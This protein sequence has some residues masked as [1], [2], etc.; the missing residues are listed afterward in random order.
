MNILFVTSEAYPLIKTGGLA[1]VSSGL[2]A[3]LAALGCDVRV[4]LPAYPEALDMVEAKGK[5]LALGDLLETGESR[6]LSSRMPDSGV[7][8]LLVDCPALFDRPGGPYVDAK[9]HIWPDNHLRFAMLSMAAA[10]VCKNGAD[11][12]RPDV[13]H[14]NDWHTGLVPAYLKRMEGP[15]IP[16][17]FTI[18]NLHYQ[19]LFERKVLEGIGLTQEDFTIDGVEYFGKVSFMKAGIQFSERITTVSPTYAREIQDEKMGEGL[20]GLLSAKASVLSGILNGVDY[21]LWNPDTDKAISTNYSASN[22]DR[23]VE[24]KRDLQRDTGLGELDEAPLLGMVCRFTHQKGIDLLLNALA[25][26]FDL[27]CQLV[28]LGEGEAKFERALRAA[29][30][31]SPKRMAVTIGYDEALA[32][33][34]QAGVDMVLV[35]SR[36][37]P[38]G[39]TQLYALKYGTLPVARRTGGLADSVLDVSESKAGTGFVFGDPT[40]GE[41]LR[42]VRRGVTLYGRPKEWRKVQKTAMKQDFSWRKAADEY[43]SLYKELI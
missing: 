4:I 1:D 41:L 8:V 19:G 42:A 31:A 6:L 37:E 40:P 29:A 5:S 15:K 39:L 17:V 28:V 9:G 10:R 35:P 16:S 30:A 34:I 33:R 24:N 21:A 12:W 14:A 3:A 23:K 25:G 36:Y 32:H 38:C 22:L 27:G 26:I 7:P 2:P 20:H 13:L 18:H 43:L 11:G